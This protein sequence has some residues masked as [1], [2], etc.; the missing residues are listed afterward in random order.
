M[1]L[2]K[3]N[4]YQFSEWGVEQALGELL[5]RGA[6]PDLLSPK[7]VWNHYRLVVWKLACYV[8]FWPE[9]FLSAECFCPGKVL[10]QL[11]YRY[12]REINRAERPALR[13]IV[14][15]DDS[16]SRHMVLCIA[17]I[18]SEFSEEAQND[19]LRVKV[20]DGWYILSAVVDP[21]LERSIKRG[22]LA[23]GSKIH[24]CRGKLNGA[25]NGA[26]ILELMEGD[27]SVSLVLQ[28]NNTRLARWDTKLGF[29][30]SPLLWTKRLRSI[31]P[32]GGLVPGVDVVVLRKYPVV[33]LETLS[34]GVT[35]IKRTARE[36]E[37]AAEA[38][39]ESLQSRYQQ[40]VQEV[41]KEF[42]GSGADTE[43]I[44]MEVESRAHEL[45]SEASRNV[46]PMF[47]IRVGNYIVHSDRDHE[48]EALVTF[49]SNVHTPY[50]E[51]HRV[52]VGFFRRQSLKLGQGQY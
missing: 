1:T 4:G 17:D 11:A 39:Q 6:T 28:A 45:Q 40:I 13:K 38:H 44:R 25:D 2:T 36:E 3:A 46:T 50:S 21:T 9:T 14:E 7:W 19:S 48:E 12:E 37:R 16:A 30:S 49:W 47:T 31:T 26:A 33:Y 23:I 24:V 20:T 32:E 52:R 43:A 27:S 41:E 29:Q 42:G 34:D 35:K 10:D 18:A 22:R 15:G 51:G 5:R 8:R